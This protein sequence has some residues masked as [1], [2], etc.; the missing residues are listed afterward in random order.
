MTAR[1]DCPYCYGTGVW[2]ENVNQDAE[3]TRPVWVE[4]KC[5]CTIEEADV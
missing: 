2:L 3:D 4:H 5:T 1:S